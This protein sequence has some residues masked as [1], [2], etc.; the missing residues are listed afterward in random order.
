MAT[1]G[2]FTRLLVIALLIF[3]FYKT[4]SLNTID[5]DK[6]IKITCLVIVFYCANN[7]LTTDY[8]F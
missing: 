1:I 6:L 4:D 3:Y 8:V 5:K 7:Y 2:I